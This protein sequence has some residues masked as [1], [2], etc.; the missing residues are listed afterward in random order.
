[1]EFATAIKAAA[2]TNSI[3]LK[4]L[5]WFL[6][7]ALMGKTNGPGIAELIDMLGGQEALQRIE[8]VVALF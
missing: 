2:K 6:R 7:L 4:E 5:F 1:V 8:K 3:P